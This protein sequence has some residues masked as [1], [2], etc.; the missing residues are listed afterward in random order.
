MQ[1]AAAPTAQEAARVT[2]SADPRFAQLHRHYPTIDHLRRRARRRVPHFAFEYGD[3]GSGKDDAG[4]SRNWSA[5]DAIELVPR[6][7]VMPT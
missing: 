3:G 4:I 7:G 6:Y 1:H 2:E 5:F